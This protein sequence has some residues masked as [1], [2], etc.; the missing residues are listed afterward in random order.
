MEQFS[1]VSASLLLLGEPI[2]L[3]VGI[4]M[5]QPTVR[6]LTVL[7]MERFGS[8]TAVWFL[9]RKQLLKQETDET[10]NMEDFDVLKKF[11]TYD[12]ILRQTFCDSVLFFLHKKVE[13]LKMQN[14]IFIGELQSGIELTEELFLE[15]QSVVRI[16][17]LQKEE[18]LKTKNAPRSKRAEQ[19]HERILQGQKKL[20]DVRKEKGTDD[21]A[22]KI[23]GI[24]AHGYKFEDVFNMTVFQFNALIEKVVQVE[25][26][27]I[28]AMLSPY[29]S[30]NSKS[31]QKHWLE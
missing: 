15:I 27:N 13:F 3:S 18:D 16:I 10:W 30:K 29:M 14:S 11:L 28:T 20:D 22:S 4:D 26:Y 6:D 24:A 1:K 7:G 9:S 21:L 23:V 5:F 12:P 8:I 25:N 31:K 2:R 19:I 17:T